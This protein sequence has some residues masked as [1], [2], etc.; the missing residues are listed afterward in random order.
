MQIS[1]VWEHSSCS[2]FLIDRKFEVVFFKIVP[3]NNL[4]EF[5]TDFPKIG[6][7]VEEI[8]AQI[9]KYKFLKL[10]ENCFKNKCFSIDMRIPAENGGVDL[11]FQIVFTP[12]MKGKIECVVCT[13]IKNHQRLD[14]LKQ[15]NDYSHLTSNQ[16]RSLTVN[17][18]N[19]F[20]VTSYS[21]LNGYDVSK[22]NQLLSDVNYQAKKLDSTIK[23]L[24]MSLGKPESNNLLK[25]EA[26]EEN[27][28]HVVLVDDDLMTIKVHQALI[29]KQ[30]R[31]KHVVL[32]N[33][34]EAA[35]GYIMQNKPD[36]ILLD[37]HMPNI[38]GLRFLQMMDD[39]SL[40]I[41]V[42]VVSS[43]VDPIEKTT[44]HSFHFV[45]N[46]IAKPLTSEKLKLIF[47]N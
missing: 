32:F 19:L 27:R 24:C 28:R 11:P 45:K 2:F 1:K 6:N 40:F 4:R 39:N 31:E 42:V 7:N 13:I 35:L 33:N 25:K 37:L 26:S 17:V 20:N 29:R 16:L 10:L 47:D 22:I 12:L 14:H 36:L 38:D 15:L 5:I 46:F 9:Y 18:S 34:P 41:D 43:S 21:H 8:I 44:A 30:H 3:D 23:E